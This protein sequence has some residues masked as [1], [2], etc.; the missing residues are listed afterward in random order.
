LTFQLVIRTGGVQREGGQTS[1]AYIA[2]N[3]S[4]MRVADNLPD[5]TCSR[6]DESDRPLERQ[7]AVRHTIALHVCA[8]AVVIIVLCGARA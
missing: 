2:R 7:R 4:L 8:N 5:A 1:G 6:R 3:F